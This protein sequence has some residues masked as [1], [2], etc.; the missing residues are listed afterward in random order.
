MGEVMLIHANSLHIPL[1]DKSVH[2]CVGSPPYW[3]LRD[4]GE[5]DQLGLEATPEAYV[6]ALVAVFREVKRVLRDD[7]VIFVV[8]GDSYNAAGR[9]GHGTRTGT[10]QGTNRAS[11]AGQDLHRPT[12]PTLK[13]K[14]LVGIPWRVAFALQADGWWL[15]SDIIWEK[16]L[17]GGATVYARTQKGEMPMMVKDLVRLSPKTVQ[18]WDGTKWNQCVEFEE[19]HEHA[20]SLEIELRNGERIGCTKDHRWP[21][22]G[23]GILTRAE[24]LKIGQVLQPTYLPEP[25][26]PRIPLGLDDT[27]IG[28]FVGLY[29]AE[30]NRD[31]KAIHLASHSKEQERFT[32]CCRIAEAYDGTCTWTFGQGYASTIHV[33]SPVLQGIL[34]T[35]VSGNLA[36]G[37]HLHPRC[38]KRSNIFLKAILDGYLHGDGHHAGFRWRIGFCQ[39]DAL[40]AD[41]RT[42]CSRVGYSLHLRRYHHRLGDRR[43]PGWRGDIAFDPATRKTKDTEIVAIR[44]SRARRY[45]MISLQEAPHVFALTCG[46]LTGN[47]NPMPESV[48]DRPTKAHEY[49]FMLTKSEYY[50]YDAEAIREQF[51]EHKIGWLK[52]GPGQT[53]FGLDGVAVPGNKRQQK[54]TLASRPIES[55][56]NARSVWTFPEP[57]VRLR[58]DL[59]P[60]KRD[61]VMS[62]LLRRGLL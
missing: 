41:L 44:Q 37:K 59:T 24:D 49:V 42:L 52:S 22:A 7:G 17:S 36:Y 8:L 54:S 55:G 25:K 60:E 13:P 26:N 43:F 57:M 50:F 1:R 62:E 4:Y 33:R 30:G 15:R 29:I 58:D 2:C 23:L 18:L 20:G 31:G 21:L 48:K 11:A 3:K 46:V 14:D 35:Y 53:C 10:K 61:Y 47:S 45:W 12:A 6:A 16:C 9:H 32:R 38:W 27:D 56:R 19:Q 28:W 51:S 40:A 34:D 5:P 39:N